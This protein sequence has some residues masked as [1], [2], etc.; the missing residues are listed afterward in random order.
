MQN[1]DNISI[2]IG[3]TL[4]DIQVT[5]EE[6]KDDRII[7]VVSEDEKYIMYHS[8]D[9]CEHV[10]IED[11]TGDIKDLIG[12][13]ILKAEE[14]TNRENPKPMGDFDDESFTWTFYHL[15]TINGYVTIRWYGTSN[16]YYSERADFARY[17]N[18][19]D[20]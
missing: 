11:I 5:K 2:L 7:F 3:K 15:A 12:F 19:A 6:N 9:C 13:P 14:S 20:E 16:G 18:A 17:N 10:R 1:E 4:T 8:Q